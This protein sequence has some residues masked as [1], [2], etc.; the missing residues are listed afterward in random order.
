MRKLVLVVMDG[1]GVIDKVEGN[2]FKNA[3]TPNIDNLMKNSPN[4]L[5]HAHGTYVGLPSDDDMGNSEVGHNAIGCGQIYS[6]GAKLVNEAIESKE[7]FKSKTWK[8]L[9]N[10][11][12][13]NTLHFIGLLSDGNVHS[14]ISHLLVMLEQAKNDGIK[15]VRIHILLDGRDVEKQS[16]L[17]YVEMLE[18]KMKEL[19]D[20][21]FDSMIASGGGRMTITMDR[22]EA[23]WSMV[24]K[25]WHTHVLGEGKKFESA[26]EAIETYR[27]ENPEIVDQDLDSFVIVKDDIPVG[28]INDNDSVIFFNFRGDRAIEISHAFDDENFDK[29]DRINYP[30]VMYAGMLQYDTEIK[31]P[32]LFLAEPPK[33]HNT[34]TEELSKH[35][36]REYAI[37]ET[38]KFGHVTYFWNG[39]HQ[40]K[41]NEELETWEEVDSDVISFDKKPKMKANEITDKLI[42]A[43]KSDKYDFLRTNFPNGDM[44][45]HTGNY[46][47]TIKGLEA[48]DYNIGRIVDAVK[49]TDSIL[50]VTA[51]H[52]NSEEMINEKG[53]A[54]T[55]HTTNPVPFIIYNKNIKFK[56]GDFGLANIA[57]TIC[58][59]LEIEKNSNWKESMIETK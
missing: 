5:I 42:D 44:V 17:K 39:N 33:I 58:D 14:N 24:E 1:V 50:I 36:I 13:Y 59:L 41:I 19:N 11:C 18:N 43:I 40:D 15:K 35:N 10:Y 6:Q 51:D 28:T 4:I 49:D 30:K 52:G 21:N 9:I 2:A 38:Q 31:I 7:M 26:T 16:A 8:D 55:S 46:E 12:K 22:Y 29:F 57:S 27:K 48:V 37:S 20:E 54:K 32:R 23:D 47:A 25:G 3:K 34:L 53:E 45:G 56:D